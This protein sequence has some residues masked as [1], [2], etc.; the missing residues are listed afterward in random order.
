MICL[1]TNFLIGC[2]VPDS[3]E[4]RAVIRWRRSGESLC[5]SGI[6]W[7]EFL[8]CPVNAEQMAIVNALLNSGIMAFGPDEARE[9]ARLFNE[10][11]RMRRLRVDSMIV[12]TALLHDAR[13]A[14]ANRDDFR[15][16]VALGLDVVREAEIAD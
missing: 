11:G 14:T 12:A 5:T 4:A 13:L 10:T 8:C 2:L 7:F 9:A 3:P 16:F 6:C 15:P 1:D